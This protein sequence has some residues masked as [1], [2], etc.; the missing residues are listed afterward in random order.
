MIKLN[1]E[2]FPKGNVWIQESGAEDAAPIMVLGIYNHGVTFGSITTPQAIKDFPWKQLV[3][4]GEYSIDG[5]VTWIKF[6]EE[7]TC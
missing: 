3:E 2:T 4:E 6:S 7:Y 1:K 5:R